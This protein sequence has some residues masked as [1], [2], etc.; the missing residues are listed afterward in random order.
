VQAWAV[1]LSPF[2]CHYLVWSMN[3]ELVDLRRLIMR[4]SPADV[5]A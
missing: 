5:T 2:I 4:T 3:K 1:P